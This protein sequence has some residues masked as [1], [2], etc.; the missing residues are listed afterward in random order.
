MLLLKK[1][2]MPLVIMVGIA[3]AYEQ[4]LLE[5]LVLQ[6]NFNTDHVMQD[7]EKLAAPT[8][9]AIFTDGTSLPLFRAYP[10]LATTVSH[11]SLG[12]FPTPVIYC[13]TIGQT[14]GV[15]LYVKNDGATGKDKG[16]GNKLFGGNKV[17]HLEFLLADAKAQKA[18][19]VI[20]TGAAGSNHALA[21]ALYAQLVGLQPICLLTHQA[22][23]ANVQRNLLLHAYYGIELRYCS[24]AQIQRL[25]I[26]GEC[27][28]QK[29]LNNKFPY[30]IPLG[31]A[32]PCGVLGFVNAAFELKEQIAA[33]QLPEPDRIYIACGSAGSAAGLLLGIKAAGLK[34]MLVPVAIKPHMDVTEVPQKIVRLVQEANQL[35]HEADATFPLVAISIDDIRVLEEYAGTDYGVFTPEAKQAII[36]FQAAEGIRLDGTYTGKAAA[37]MLADAK[38]HPDQVILFWDTFCADEFTDIVSH[39]DYHQLPLLFHPYFEQPIPSENSFDF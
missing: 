7:L 5:S 10:A 3:I 27:L 36:L 4:Q 19:A 38:N 16:Q 12:D 15:Q 9:S 23:A 17:R 34:S 28:R 33:G 24:S 22:N 35:L 6:Y 8:E 25:G 11:I 1:R 32:C 29:Q 20:T 14:M 26:W 31:G 30:F 2:F 21:T 18:S 39:V 13:P 37:G